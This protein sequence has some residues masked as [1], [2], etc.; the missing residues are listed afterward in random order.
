MSLHQTALVLARDGTG[1]AF[2][3]HR[4]RRR[5]RAETS[6]L[7]C[8]FVG[9]SWK[10]DRGADVGVHRAQSPFHHV[11]IYFICF[12][13][14]LLLSSFFPAEGSLILHR[15]FFFFFTVTFMRPE[16]VHVFLWLS[17]RSGVSADWAAAKWPFP[18]RGGRPREA[19]HF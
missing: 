10:K 17:L 15:V 8:V 2:A 18:F 3:A 11:E 6:G 1:R 19:L 7:R 13:L 9:A 5:P 4:E 16:D 14:R 12:Y